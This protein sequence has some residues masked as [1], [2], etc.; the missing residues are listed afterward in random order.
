MCVLILVPLYGAQPLLKLRCSARGFSSWPSL[1][2]TWA[3]EHSQ[4]ARFSPELLQAVTHLNNVRSRVESFV[5]A[6]ILHLVP[7]AWLA[8]L[9]LPPQTSNKKMAYEKR[10]DD[11]HLDLEE[12]LYG[13]AL[14]GLPCN[15]VDPLNFYLVD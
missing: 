15:K 13:A 14:M 7:N 3:L 2:T 1:K 8:T 12:K 10:I 4:P 11:K 9:Q 5:Q 6:F